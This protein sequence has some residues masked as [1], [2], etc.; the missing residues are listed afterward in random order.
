MKADLDKSIDSLSRVDHGASEMPY[1]QARDSPGATT[2]PTTSEMDLFYSELYFNYF[3]M[4]IDLN[5]SIL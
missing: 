4:R 3:L 1:V 5:R 2:P